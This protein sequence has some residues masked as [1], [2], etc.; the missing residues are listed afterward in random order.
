MT[1][2]ASTEPSGER[3]WTA[4][5]VILNEGLFICAQLLAKAFLLENLD[6][7]LLQYKRSGVDAYRT[8]IEHFLAPSPVHANSIFFEE[9]PP[10]LKGPLQPRR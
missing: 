3:S 7:D 2:S 6:G 5:L 1:G 9:V 8:A 10:T 4:Y